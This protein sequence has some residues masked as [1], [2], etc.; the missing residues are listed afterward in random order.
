MKNIREKVKL[1]KIASLF[2]L[3]SVTIPIIFLIIKLVLLNHYDA[4]TFLTLSVSIMVLIAFFLP[5]IASKKWKLTIPKPIYFSFII[6]L[7]C[8]AFLGEL[9]GFYYS[10]P[11]WDDL[12]HFSSGILLGILG[13][14]I[15]LGLSS[16]KKK[17][18][19]LSPVFVSLFAFAFSVSCG[20][21]WEIFEF[22]FDILFKTN[23]QKYMLEGGKML[24]GNAALLDTMKDL[25]TDTVSSLIMSI[26]G[27]ISIKK[28]NSILDKLV[29]K[30]S[31]IK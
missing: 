2:I 16:S 23:M 17:I 18:V 6:F 21:I 19:K 5:S 22:L 13:F 7:Y 25:I 10:V 11:F 12:L 31:D 29:I 26:I 24:I 27:Y 8:A 9:N 14:S 4:E 15:L 20:V 28:D 3:L 1:N 30:R